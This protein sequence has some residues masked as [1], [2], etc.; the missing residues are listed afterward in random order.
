M[1]LSLKFI[2]GIHLVEQLWRSLVRG[3]KGIARLYS[4]LVRLVIFIAILAVTEVWTYFNQVQIQCSLWLVFICQF[5]SLRISLVEVTLGLK[6][7]SR[8]LV[9]LMI[10]ECHAEL[11]FGS[12]RCNRNTIIVLRGG[13]R[14]IS[15]VLGDITIQ[16]VSHLWVFGGFKFIF[17]RLA[18]LEETWIVK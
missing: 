11:R 10:V 18:H 4:L 13:T 5:L 16:P 14:L 17:G 9:I 3:V 2:K 8:F 6:G 7:S 15:V 1:L 12:L